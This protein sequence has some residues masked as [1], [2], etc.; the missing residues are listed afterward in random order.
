MS[1]SSK[2][3]VFGVSGQVGTSLYRLAASRPHDS[4][5]FCS[6]SKL[7]GDHATVL[8]DLLDPKSIR[9]V[10]QHIKPTVIINTAAYTAVDKAE[11]DRDHAQYINGNAPGIMGQAAQELGALMVHYST[12]YVFKGDGTN[13]WTEQDTPH[14]VNYYGQT[15]LAG[16]RAVAEATK[17]AL[18][19]RTQWVYSDVGHNFVKTMLRLGTERSELK[20]VA[21]QIGA[22]TSADVIAQATFELIDRCKN[23]DDFGIYHLACSGESSWYE[24]AQAIF[25]GARVRGQHLA[26]ERLLPI[27]SSEYPTPAERPKNSRLDLKKIERQLARSMPTWQNALQSVLT[28]LCGGVKTQ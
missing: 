26:I 12:D 9:Q 20:V 13:H 18:I 6:R 25:Q 24:F 16:E 19:L 8:C 14:P 27:A 21:D 5:V 2:Y 23:P 4:F 10:I 28:K 1:P 15:K 22:P 7:A 17:R 11:T 3:L